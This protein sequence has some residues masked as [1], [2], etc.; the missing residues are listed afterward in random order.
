M[1]VL[2]SLL[3]F[4]RL[5]NFPPVG[6]D[7]AYQMAPAHSLLT[8]GVWG[9]A[10]LGGA[11]SE[12]RR[13]HP[14][15]KTYFQPPLYLLLVTASLKCL[16]FGVLQTR[17]VSALLGF[18]TVAVTYLL[19][20]E[21]T[22]RRIAA[23]AASLL[24]LSAPLFVHISRRARPESAVTFFTVLAVYLFV[25]YHQ[26]PGAGWAL[27]TGL[28]SAAALM[29]HYNG[30]FGLAAVLVL[31]LIHEK[32][33]G[34]NLEGPAE[35]NSRSRLL[36]LKQYLTGV[37]KSKRIALFLLGIVL[38]SLPYAI[39]VL[40]DYEGGFHNFRTQIS[41]IG[42]AA[43]LGTFWEHVR[44]ESTR[45]R[46]FFHDYRFAPGSAFGIGLLYVCVIAFALI[47]HKSGYR[48]LLIVLG[49]NLLL[50]IYPSPNKTPIY[51]GVVLPYLTTLIS[52]ALVDLKDMP[53]LSRPHTARCFYVL[54]TLLISM[55]LCWNGKV[56]R[57][58]YD[59]YRD[60]D[61]D[62]TIAQLRA[63]IPPDCTTIMGR[64][65]FWIG[66]NDYEYYR[67]GFRDFE[68]IA[69]IRPEIFIYSDL[70]MNRPGSAEL[71]LQL[72][73]YFKEHAEQIGRVKGSPNNRCMCGH[74][75]IYRVEWE[76]SIR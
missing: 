6:N 32:P 66:L 15:E 62:N 72:D 42:R 47:R 53:R 21:M 56:W 73:S 35:P 45:Y 46:R 48:T 65:S 12:W 58:Y 25:K 18:G 27:L 71:K 10:P 2:Y 51:L 7:D 63:V 26:R 28:A 41:V 5:A 49:I 44:A 23:T 3:V 43:T 30:I 11:A 60:C 34:H 1:L 19:A 55:L 70:G 8:R 14:D 17:L 59:K 69:S 37:C 36:V 64:Y 13:S 16:G 50:L 24:L 76:S 74:L 31:F 61:F 20:L 54:A 33:V 57:S 52:L 75:R 39:Y 40:L 22:R 38:I 4:P 9:S 67:Y 29:S 68:D